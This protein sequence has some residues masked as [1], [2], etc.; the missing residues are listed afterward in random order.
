M[1]DFVYTSAFTNVRIDEDI[2]TYTFAE[3]A[4]HQEDDVSRLG[5]IISDLWFADSK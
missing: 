3:R 2:A 5:G 1:I 4:K